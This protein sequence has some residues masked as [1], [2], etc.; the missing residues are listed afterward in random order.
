MD[1][2]VILSISKRVTQ[3]FI[4]KFDTYKSH[5]PKQRRAKNAAIADITSMGLSIA[6]GT[7]MADADKSFIKTSTDSDSGTPH[8]LSTNE[9]SSTEVTN[10]I[11]LEKLHDLTQLVTAL[12]KEVKQLSSDNAMLKTQF[13]T[14]PTSPPTVITPA[15]ITDKDEQLLSSPASGESDSA[16]FVLD[17]KQNRRRVRRNKHANKPSNAQE[18]NSKDGS[19]QTKLH[20]N[21][22]DGHERTVDLWIGGVHPTCVA[23]ELLS[24]LNSMGV[25]DCTTCWLTTTNRGSSYKVTVPSQNSQTALNSENWP[26][27][28]IS[29]PYR[30]KQARQSRLRASAAPQHHNLKHSH[31]QNKPRNSFRGNSRQTQARHNN[32]GHSNPN[33][34]HQYNPPTFQH[35]R[36]T[37]SGPQNTQWNTQAFNSTWPA[38]PTQTQ[39]Q[40]HMWHQPTYTPLYTNQVWQTI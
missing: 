39:P 24:H 8:P 30:P 32:S 5:K 22:D 13:S 3:T 6:N 28:I 34:T 2:D 11:L 33:P 27:G 25:K 35:H 21:N 36:N 12:Q 16:G 40:Q 10:A 1:T 14:A 23:E 7:V 31:H 29:R 17:R 37:T 38:L 20:Q 9:T 19:T 18:L 4:D 15:V 26:K